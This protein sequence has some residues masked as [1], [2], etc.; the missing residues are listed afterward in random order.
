MGTMAFQSAIMFQVQPWP[1][2]IGKL[3][4]GARRPPIAPYVKVEGLD[5]LD[6]ALRLLR[7][8]LQLEPR[9][10]KYVRAFVRRLNRD[11]APTKIYA[12][13]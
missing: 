5:E 3:P 1:E 11:G 6:A 13:E 4:E 12:A 8:P 2:G 7:M 10:D 9:H